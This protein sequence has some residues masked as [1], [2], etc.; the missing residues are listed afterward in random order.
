MR[1]LLISPPDPSTR[2]LHKAL[3]ESA[4]SVKG[5]D[6]IPVGL[7]IAREEEFDVLLIVAGPAP[8]ALPSSTFITSILELA[9][10]KGPPAIVV[11]LT[12]ASARERSALLRAGADACFVQPYSFMEIHERMLALFRTAPRHQS[13]DTENAHTINRMTQELVEGGKRL[14]LTKREYLV[15]ECLLRSRGLPVGREQL[16]QY[17]WPENDDADPSVVNLFISRLRKKLA[18]YK[19]EANIQTISGFGYQWISALMK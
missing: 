13:S 2:Y 12:A 4:H 17:A 16:L 8:S 5:A 6:T 11:L 1:V 15:V 14:P 18:D 10:L 9:R 19:L 7:C 3:R